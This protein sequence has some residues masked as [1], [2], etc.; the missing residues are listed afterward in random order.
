MPQAPQGAHHNI[1]LPHLPLF[2]FVRP[3]FITCI[4]FLFCSS[5]TTSALNVNNLVVVA[6][7]SFDKR[8]HL[9]QCIK[10]NRLRPERVLTLDSLQTWNCY[11]ISQ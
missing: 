1:S 5:N 8:Q 10:L 11:C 6:V 4:D 3:V 9:H 2:C 7:K